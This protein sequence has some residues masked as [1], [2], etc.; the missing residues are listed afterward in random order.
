MN[1]QAIKWAVG[2]NVDIITMSWAIDEFSPRNDRDKRIDKLRDAIN[3]AAE[4]NILMFCANPDKGADYKINKTFPK[5]LVSENTL[6][7]IGAAT[8]DGGNP[9]HRIAS[10]DK[11]CNFLLPGTELAVR[12]QSS[13]KR[14]ATKKTVEDGKPPV[15]WENH[16]GSSLS[17]ALAAGLAAMILHCALASGIQADDPR[18]TWLKTRNG[19]NEALRNIDPD[20]RGDGNNTWLPV[21]RTFGVTAKLAKW[22]P[23]SEIRKS[24]YK[25]VVA[26]LLVKAPSSDD[27]DP[28][29]GRLKRQATVRESE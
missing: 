25:D 4:A 14:K 3:M 22:A 17:C 1:Q 13:V 27:S 9:W 8:K 21:S 15:E 16:S 10:G 24:L 20:G 6:F 7:V 5:S 2:E 19:M 12:V 18:W 23:E 28:V 11:S 29:P 26:K